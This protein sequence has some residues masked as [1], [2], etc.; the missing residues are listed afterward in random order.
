MGITRAIVIID[1]VGYS[2]I[3]EQ[4]EQ[5]SDVDVVTRLNQQIQNFVD[6]GLI[7]ARVTRKQAVIKT[8]GD[9]A[10]LALTN[11]EI[12]H[13][14]SA[15]VHEA[16]RAHN[17][18]RSMAIAKRLFRI[19]IATGEI[20][21][22]K[23]YGNKDIAGTT[24]S[25]AA[26]L[27]PKAQPGGVLIDTDTYAA[28]P[29]DLKTLYRGPQKI[30][31]KRDETFDA[32][33]WQAN[34]QGVADAAALARGGRGAA[35]VVAEVVP[36]S[37]I[38]AGTTG[39]PPRTLEGGGD[40]VSGIAPAAT[41]NRNDVS[42][43]QDLNYQ[44]LLN[45][46]QQRLCD[47]RAPAVTSA[48]F[49]A[50]RTSLH[51]HFPQSVDSAS[52]IVAAIAC[53][54]DA[55]DADVGLLFDAIHTAN[56]K[57]QPGDEGLTSWAIELTLFTALRCI[58]LSYWSGF[59]AELME[60]VRA[61]HAR[62]GSVASSS[63]LIAS[64]GVAGLLGQPFRLGATAKPQGVHEVARVAPIL[65]LDEAILC[66]IYDSLPLRPEQRRANAYAVLS[67]RE[68][69]V[70]RLHFRRL[71]DDGQLSAVFIGVP[72]PSS[73]TQAMVNA[74]VARTINATVI[75]G[76][77][78]NAADL[79]R[80]STTF[81]VDELQAAVDDIFVA[82]AKVSTSASAE[83]ERSPP[84]LDA[85]LD[86]YRWH[87]FMSHASDDKEAFVVPLCDELT[88][89]GLKVWLDKERVSGGNGLSEAVRDGLSGSRFGVTVLSEHYFDKSWTREEFDALHAMQM[90]K[91]RR[92]ILPVRLRIT[93]DD[94]VQK[95]PLVGKLLS[96]DANDGAAVVARQLL[97]VVMNP[98]Q[99]LRDAAP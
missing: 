18:T 28:L 71:R 59:A 72:G 83:N 12:A 13:R 84:N 14:F 51:K 32:Y 27:E 58:D 9:G 47:G 8:T 22:A 96:F 4:L 68:K 7:A 82:L 20:A 61:P 19:G 53:F 34:A 66:Q 11:A 3:S 6:A 41:S 17:A 39:S 77:H 16:T 40:S 5:S 15:T 95:N 75:Q 38:A 85:H 54:R 78:E 2:S 97:E 88:K 92:H 30:A 74:I 99:P 55:S 60:D 86:G 37:Q 25:R 65:E 89:L 94:V 93:H 1:L 23:P 80:A 36:S 42:A 45:Q 62:V 50:L 26:R 69:G 98:D 49:I 90:S 63:A 24:I 57:L 79:V 31:G 91:R 73:E 52:D 29:P 43:S 67:E 56:G 33:A 87:L 35:E 76:H 10:I 44:S 48:W 81:T 64:I 21:E 46:F 70:L